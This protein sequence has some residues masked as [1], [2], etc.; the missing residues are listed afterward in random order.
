MPVDRLDEFGLNPVVTY[1]RDAIVTRAHIARAL[2][3]SES[4]VEKMDLPLFAA[5]RESRYLWGQVLDVL[6][7]RALPTAR[8]SERDAAT[9]S[10]RRAS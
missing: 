9:K 5:G 10:I 6:A 7:E 8:S 4:T 3:L 2:G 1:P